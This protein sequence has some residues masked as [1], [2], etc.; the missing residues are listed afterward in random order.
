MDGMEFQPASETPAMPQNVA[1]EVAESKPECPQPAKEAVSEAPAA[2]A[3]QEVSREVSEAKPESSEAIKTARQI[4][5]ATFEPEAVVERAGDYKQAEA[6]EA[7]FVKT[8]DVTLLQPEARHPE[9]NSSDASL[10]PGSTGEQ[11]SETNLQNAVTEN[12]TKIIFDKTPD[13]DDQTETTQANPHTLEQVFALK[14]T[15]E[16]KLQSTQ[17]T[18]LPPVTGFRIPGRDKS[19]DEQSTQTQPEESNTPGDSVDSPAEI[20]D[21]DQ[22]IT[23]DQ[24][25]EST[26]QTEGVDVTEEM[27]MEAVDNYMEAEAEYQ[28]LLDEYQIASTEGGEAHE[29][30]EESRE[31]LD[32]T[33]ADFNS[34]LSENYPYTSSTSVLDVRLINGEYVLVS[35]SN[36]CDDPSTWP[37]QD[38]YDGFCVVK[39]EL[40]DKLS[41]FN[42][43][44]HQFFEKIV[45]FNNIQDSL[46]QATN[47]SAAARLEAW[48][49]LIEVY[50]EERAREIL[51]E[52][53]AQVESEHST[54]NQSEDTGS[55]EPQSSDQTEEEMTTQQTN[56]T[57]Q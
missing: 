50:G 38:A 23:E 6:L 22:T 9:E 5:Q 8:V 16:E 1:P 2:A 12:L 30:M 44:Y 54:A 47:N 32:N 26:D 45:I 29:A 19:E 36:I 56:N 48:Q 28:R 4:E 11:V 7:A 40:Q 13:S 43:A 27:A 52:A 25:L 39:T 3:I 42:Q 37:S 57:D 35:A 49:S 46:E 34:Y 18:E 17:E 55:T 41:E 14:P 51:D 21:E 31:V 53:R 24:D 33:I 15:V 20:T 10:E